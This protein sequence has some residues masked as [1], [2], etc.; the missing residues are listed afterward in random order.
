MKIA[1]KPIRIKG[2]SRKAQA[3][4]EVVSMDRLGMPAMVMA[5]A[6]QNSDVTV[7]SYI[8]SKEYRWEASVWLRHGGPGA[9]ESRTEGRTRV[10]SC[11]CS[12]IRKGV[13]D[14]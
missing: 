14:G 2:F 5:W 10:K 7:N 9:K 12:E 11:L 3:H 4:L 8:L 13:R 1:Q 6:A